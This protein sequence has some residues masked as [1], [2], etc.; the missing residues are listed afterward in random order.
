MSSRTQASQGVHSVNI[1]SA[2]S[3]NSLSATPAKGQGGVELVLDAHEGIK[4]HRS[5]FVQIQLVGLH[6]RLFG[7][8]IGVPPV[9]LKGLDARIGGAFG[10]GV[11]GRFAYGGH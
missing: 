3:T 2:A 1:H 4:N 7:R 8:G 9:D 10:V 11:D 6:P 5:S